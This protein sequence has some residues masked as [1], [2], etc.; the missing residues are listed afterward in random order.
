MSRFHH[1]FSSTDASIPLKIYGFRHIAQ[2]V[3]CLS[4]IHEALDSIPY[5]T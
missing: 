3:E 2:L 5:I 4:R 1:Y